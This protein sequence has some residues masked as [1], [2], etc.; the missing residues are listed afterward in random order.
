MSTTTTPP[1]RRE[2]PLPL[3]MRGDLVVEPLWFGGVRYWSVKDPLSLRYFQLRDEEHFILRTLDG[4][5]GLEGVKAEFERE[6]APRK[7]DARHL[8]MFLGTLHRWGLIVA[9]VP[10]Q[11]EQLRRRRDE[12][13]RQQW[14]QAV[15]GILAIRF[16]GVDPERLLCW[17]YPKCRWLFS[18]AAV[19]ACLL[20]ALAALTLLAVEYETLQR[21]LPDFH[22]FFN[23]KNALWIAAALAAT[24]VLHEFGHALACKHF[25]GECH[26][27]GVMLLV[28]TPC[29]YCNVSDAWMM[30]S[31]WRRAA[32]GAAG[33]YVEL[34]LASVAT[35]LWWFSEPGL[36]NAVCL[37]VMFVCSISTIM[38]N[39]NPLLRYD[40][41]YILSDIL[42]VPNLREQAFAVVRQAL[43]GWCW[44]VPPANIRMLPSR[45]RGLL[46][47]YAVAAAIYRVVVVVA[48]LWFLHAVLKPYDLTA[49]AHLATIV[50]LAAMILG[51]LWGAVKF[52]SANARNRHVKWPRF[53]LSA[54][55]LVAV[56]I[57]VGLIPLPYRV[58]APLV[59]E[60]QAA[61]RVY[62]SVP[63]TLT[64]AVE[65][66]V[67]VP[68]NAVLATL[69]DAEIDREIVKLEGD[70]M[71]LRERLAALHARSVSTREA[72][73]QLPAT[74]KA[75]HAVEEQLA[76]RK[77]D[78]QQ[79]TLRS[80]VAGVVIPL[81]A[82]VRHPAADE[83]TTWSGTPLDKENV[84]TFLE[85]GTTV[86]LVGDP[87]QIEAVLVLDQADIEFVRPGQ[88][89][90]LV[91]RQ[92][93][94]KILWG[95]V[96]EIS[97]SRL[98]AAPAALAHTGDVPVV[99]DDNG[100]PRPASASYQ[101]RVLLDAQPHRLLPGGVG[102]S[103]IHVAPQSLVQRLQRYLS[104][105][106]RFEF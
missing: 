28:F 13:R 42:E 77:S 35:F 19:A 40:G 101:A 96:E 105:T 75:L 10:G 102:R 76:Q 8:Q 92:L 5:R 1:P 70:A 54:L 48:I 61:R 11:G 94:A 6:F 37:N 21:K 39:G 99:I 47:S 65:P 50:V 24:K 64:S 9:G 4:R 91:L 51:P 44:G 67:A 12:E 100:I 93:P 56:L 38:F 84:G 36:L 3:A 97:D 60:P 79:L 27:M 63:G 80:P 81:P 32:I 104:R 20:L 85:S 46:A 73:D 22:A 30:P 41:Y 29:L 52:L 7:I 86:C 17:L 31:K 90:R 16:R 72:G 87:L 45:R 66:G 18:Q 106:F 82:T 2:N 49:L 26:E 14:L 89:V 23:A 103:K 55:V 71:Q 62:V 57:G 53:W 68:E 69:E 25:G 34:F 78:R 83:L 88:R 33:M 59:L 74:E 43:A 15:T 58:A 98:Q 95:T